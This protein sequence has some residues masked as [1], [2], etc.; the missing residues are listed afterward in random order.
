MRNLYTVCITTVAFNPFL[1][2]LGLKQCKFL[3]LDKRVTTQVEAIEKNFHFT[4]VPRYLR[5]YWV[6]YG[7]KG[8]KASS[9][10]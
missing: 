7:G 9:W 3:T 6:L 10:S 5:K 1:L 8:L 2:K 4:K